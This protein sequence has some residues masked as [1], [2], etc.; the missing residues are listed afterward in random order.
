MTYSQAVI[1]VQQRIKELQK[2]N[3]IQDKLLWQISEF[4]AEKAIEWL[5]RLAIATLVGQE[6]DGHD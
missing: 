6:D 1:A 5:T 4:G 3:A 2:C